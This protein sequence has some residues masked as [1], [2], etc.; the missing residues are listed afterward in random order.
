MAIM[1][2]RDPENPEKPKEITLTNAD[3]RRALDT[4]I[5]GGSLDSENKLTATPKVSTVTVGATATPMPETPLE[6]RK[7]LLILNNSEVELLICNAD[8]TGA[9]PIDLSDFIKFDVPDDVIIYCKV[10]EGTQ[11]IPILEGK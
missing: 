3:G 10:A 6:G 5:Q 4:Y 9:F 7:K 2:G 11:E 1:K 8:G